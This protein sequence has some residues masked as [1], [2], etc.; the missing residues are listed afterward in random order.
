LIGGWNA[1]YDDKSG[2]PTTVNGD[3]TILV[4]DSTA[5]TVVVKGKLAIRGGSLRVNDLKVTQ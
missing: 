4:G 3:L 1:L 2:I 5:E